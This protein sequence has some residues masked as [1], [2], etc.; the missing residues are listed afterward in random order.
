MR[1][2]QKDL[3]H[4]DLVARRIKSDLAPL[5]D[6]VSLTRISEYEF[7][8]VVEHDKYVIVNRRFGRE[9]LSIPYTRALESA[10]EQMKK[11]VKGEKVDVDLFRGERIFVEEVLRF[12]EGVPSTFSIQANLKREGK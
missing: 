7:N 5:A 12:M 11:F 9:G 6:S 10:I 2:T 3:I 1:K 8:L 4:E